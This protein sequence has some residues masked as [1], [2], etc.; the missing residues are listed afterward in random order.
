[1]LTRTL[2]SSCL[3]GPP[4]RR[5]ES[6]TPCPAVPEPVDNM[7]G[8]GRDRGLIILPRY[9]PVFNRLDFQQIARPVCVIHAACPARVD[10]R[11][12]STCSS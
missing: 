1:M 12:T 7:Q 3:R 8:A 10:W 2:A 11:R 9:L 6:R 5:K 4:E